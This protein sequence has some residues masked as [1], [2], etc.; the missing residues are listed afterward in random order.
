MNGAC[1]LSVS[2]RQEKKWRIE[3]PSGGHIDFGAEGY[4][5][6][7]IHKDP[8]RK[9][10]YINRHS[11]RENW[12]L[13]GIETAGFWARWLLW[14]LPNI[15]DSMDDIEKRFNIKIIY[16]SYNSDNSSYSDDSLE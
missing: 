5:D 14:N 10:N 7:T 11:L 13:S 8:V 6:Y 9:Q 16:E 12:T 15:N 2:P 4:E 3:F 1:Y